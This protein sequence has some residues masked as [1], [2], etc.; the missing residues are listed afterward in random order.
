MHP[1]RYPRLTRFGLL[2]SGPLDLGRSRWHQPDLL[3]CLRAVAELPSDHPDPLAL[4]HSCAYA[5]STIYGC[6]VGSGSGCSPSDVRTELRVGTPPYELENLA[7]IGR[8]AARKAASSGVTI[9][10]PSDFN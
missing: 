8:A 9:V 4:D 10:F 7:Q 1:A 5:L 6:G 3:P 2:S